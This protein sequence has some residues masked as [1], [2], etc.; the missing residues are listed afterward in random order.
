MIGIRYT[1]M[2]KTSSPTSSIEIRAMRRLLASIAFSIL[3]ATWA[4]WAS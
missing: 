2:Q 3:R 4:A 1:L